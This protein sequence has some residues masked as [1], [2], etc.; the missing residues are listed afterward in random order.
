MQ[1]ALVK[2]KEML[3][4]ASYKVRLLDTECAYVNLDKAI[5]II[6]SFTLSD[7][8][9]SCKDRIPNKEY[10]CEL[11][12]RGKDAAYPVLVTAKNTEGNLFVTQAW[13]LE[14]FLERNFYDANLQPLNVIA[15]MSLPGHYTGE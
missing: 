9:I 11:Q 3:R 2:I 15:W 6:N 12:T 14:L 13:F 4:A 10:E 8:W 5:D 7:L 1:S